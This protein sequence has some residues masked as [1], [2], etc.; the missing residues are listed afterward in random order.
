M[1]K[2]T[3]DINTCRLRGKGEGEK[4]QEKTFKPYP[5]T[6]SP[7]QIK[8]LKSLT[9]QYCNRYIGA[10]QCCVLMYFYYYKFDIFW[11]L[12]IYKNTADYKFVRYR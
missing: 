8:S 2:N 9:E 1:K 5:L 6:F 10:Q 3:T 7:N 11:S 12:L 4:G